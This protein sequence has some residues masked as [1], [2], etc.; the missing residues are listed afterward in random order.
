MY[1]C[2]FSYSDA[3]RISIPQRMWFIN[4]VVK[5]IT[6]NKGGKESTD[7]VADT[8][9]GKRVEAPRNMRRV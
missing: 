2:G 4:R 6:E 3:K 9:Q 1:Y 8:M 7:P 5:E